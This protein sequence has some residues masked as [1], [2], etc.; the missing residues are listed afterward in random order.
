MSF[1]S[2]GYADHLDQCCPK[3]LSAMMEMF[4]ICFAQYSSH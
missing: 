3:E 2:Q 1:L 4:Y